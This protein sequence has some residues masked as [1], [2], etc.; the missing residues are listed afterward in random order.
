MSLRQVILTSVLVEY[1]FFVVY[2]PTIEKEE[3]DPVTAVVAGRTA[4]V[5][6]AT[7]SGAVLFSAGDRFKAGL[8]VEVHEEQDPGPASHWAASDTVSF[9][10]QRQE[11]LVASSMRDIA[12]AVWLGV[13]GQWSLRAHRSTRSAGSTLGE[14]TPEEA[15]RWL[16]QFW[17]RPLAPDKIEVAAA[18][19]TLRSR[20]IV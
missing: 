1:G 14:P 13:P 2:D 11:L 20:S 4:P 17:R 19:T 16:L 5:V 7:A 3:D 9:G 6:L 10:V 8:R 18:Q 12:A 15:E